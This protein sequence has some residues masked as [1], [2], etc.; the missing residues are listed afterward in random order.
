MKGFQYI[1][2]TKQSLDL[3]CPKVLASTKVTLIFPESRVSTCG[4]FIAIYI[5]SIWIAAL[6]WA[7]SSQIAWLKF[8]NNSIHIW[9]NLKVPV[10][11]ARNLFF[12]ILHIHHD[13]EIN[14]DDLQGNS[15]F[16]IF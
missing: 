3:F 12:E 8:Q 9:H 10:R 14:C 4:Q 5:H 11:E 2:A 6:E 7:L 1:Y 13:D 15:L 16:K